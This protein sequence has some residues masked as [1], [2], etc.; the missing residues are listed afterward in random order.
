M[1]I[2]MHEHTGRCPHDPAQ[3]PMTAPK[4]KEVS[5]FKVK[6]LQ[7]KRLGIIRKPPDHTGNEPT[8]DIHIG[9]SEQHL[10]SDKYMQ[11][12]INIVIMKALF[13]T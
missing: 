12:V 1:S 3:K 7:Q 11:F 5:L 10:Q 2:L 13:I 6:I 4:M 9:G 8:P